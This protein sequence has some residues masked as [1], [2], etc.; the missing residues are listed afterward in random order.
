MGTCWRGKRTGG[1]WGWSG[2]SKPAAEGYGFPATSGPFCRRL[3]ADLAGSWVD[4]S[5]QAGGPAGTR[6]QREAGI[7]TKPETSTGLGRA[8]S[9][10]GRSRTALGTPTRSGC[11]RSPPRGRVV[12][13][14]TGRSGR[15]G[16]GVRRWSD[17]PA[18]TWA[19]PWVPECGRRAFGN[20][21]PAATRELRNQSRTAY[22]YGPVHAAGLK[23]SSTRGG[24]PRPL[25][26]PCLPDVL[27]RWSAGQTATRPASTMLQD[28]RP[29]PIAGPCTPSVR[30][31]IHLS[32]RGRPGTRAVE[33]EP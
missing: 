26:P 17:T 18:T 22:G 30:E 31:K 23:A 27:C 21:G 4:G 8:P 20:A 28:L 3:L 16:L 29:E 2:C 15:D 7:D 12:R 9:A 19:A 25:P 10:T 11:W 14:S 33:P 6:A 1:S 13:E 32:G 5:I 24:I